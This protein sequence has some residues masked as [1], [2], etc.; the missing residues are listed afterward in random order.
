MDCSTP[1][2]PVPLYLLVCAQTHVHWIISYVI[3]HL[4]LCRPLLLL[5]SIFP[6]IRVFS[7]ESILH[8]RWPQYWSFSLS[9]S[10]EYSGLISF[11]MDWLDLLA[12]QGTQESSPA[13]QFE[14]ISSLVLCL[15]VCDSGL[16]TLLI[17]LNMLLINSSCFWMDACMH[18]RR[19][20]ILSHWNQ[21][22]N[23]W[24]ILASLLFIRMLSATI[25]DDAVWYRSG[26]KCLCRCYS[27]YKLKR[28]GERLRVYPFSADSFCA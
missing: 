27:W 15:L 12:V 20:E 25:I 21:V 19:S 23:D 7:G 26:Y 11:R 10:N 4:I 2:L 17:N 14:S 1:G 9:P 16:W 28:W 6:S 8:I 18:E 24:E 22:A 3:N 13:P 5:S